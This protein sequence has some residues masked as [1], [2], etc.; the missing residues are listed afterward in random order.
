MLFPRSS[1]C[2]QKACLDF[3]ILARTSTSCFIVS[4][5][6]ISKYWKLLTCS[7]LS[8]PFCISIF[9]VTLSVTS[10]HLVFSGFISID[11]LLL[12]VPLTSLFEFCVVDCMLKMVYHCCIGRSSRYARPVAQGIPSWRV[13]LAFI[14]QERFEELLLNKI[15][16]FLFFFPVFK[17]KYLGLWAKNFRQVS[18]ETFPGNFST[19]IATCSSLFGIW[20]ILFRKLSIKLSAGFSISILHFTKKNRGKITKKNCFFYFLSKNISV[21]F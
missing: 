18:T 1:L 2:L 10:M 12:P 8:S 5:I 4:F 14:P 13:Q 11:H 9:W 15:G 20:A 7:N 3:A 17:R 21:N 6:H 16:S 19:K